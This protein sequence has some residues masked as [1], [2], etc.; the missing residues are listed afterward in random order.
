MASQ[1]ALAAA[2]EDA[3]SIPLDAIDVSRLE[4]WSN[5]THWPYFERLRKED[6][7][8][9][10]AKSQFGAYWSITKFNDIMAVD[11][12][13]EVFSSDREIIIFDEAK[14]GTDL[15]MFIAMDPPKHD[16]Q[17]KVVSPIV[18]P[19]QLARMES[20]IRERAGEDPRRT[21]DRRDVRLGRQ[22]LDR[23]DHADAGDAVRLP[24]RGPAQAD[25]LVRHHDHVPGPGR[26]VETVDEQ[27]RDYHGVPRL[28]HEAVERAGQR[29][30]AD[31]PDLDARARAMRRGT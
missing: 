11:T 17:R 7:I 19:A 6:P 31:R 1:A 13:H 28:L 26:L 22:G 12:N 29:R 24:V 15:P 18:A 14:D 9:Y 25:L 23:T 27:T 4:L 8:H 5:D 21:A 16:A 10:C 20:L 30:T 2:I 3:N